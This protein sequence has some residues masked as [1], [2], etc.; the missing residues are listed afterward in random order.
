MNE[1][2]LPKLEGVSY[3]TMNQKE[4]SCFLFV[5]SSSTF[6]D[7]AAIPALLN[8]VNIILFF[9]FFLLGKPPQN[10]DSFLCQGLI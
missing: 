3:F 9:S 1:N 10:I 2:S 7:Q 6:G 8:V 5:A 4:G